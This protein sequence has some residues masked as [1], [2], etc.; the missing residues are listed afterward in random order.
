MNN[1][2][3]RKEGNIWAWLS[4]GS[5]EAADGDLV[6]RGAVTSVVVEAKTRELIRLWRGSFDWH[7][8]GVADWGYGPTF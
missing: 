1:I 5:P 6:A 8:V 3:V 4:F 2:W 7:T